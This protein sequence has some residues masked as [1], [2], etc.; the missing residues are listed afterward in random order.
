[1]LFSLWKKLTNL[2]FVFSWLCQ[3][4]LKT[5][6]N[7]LN[8]LSESF[9]WRRLSYSYR[10][11]FVKT[12][13]RF[14]LKTG[15]SVSLFVAVVANRTWFCLCSRGLVRWPFAADILCSQSSRCSPECAACF[16]KYL[17]TTAFVIHM[18][19]IIHEARSDNQRKHSDVTKPRYSVKVTFLSLSLSL[20]FCF[21]RHAFMTLKSLVS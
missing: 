9:Q 15:T 18:L 5:L 7:V 14:G 11:I 19:Q 8:S 21:D 12:T 10:V 1:M 20:A 16:R 2:L 6:T 13:T 4:W 3:K 17:E